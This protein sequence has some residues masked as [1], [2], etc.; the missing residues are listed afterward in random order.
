MVTAQ[1]DNLN[2]P[3]ED[4]VKGAPE[5][6]VTDAALV[7]HLRVEYGDR[8]V[9]FLRTAQDLLGSG[10]KSPCLGEAVVCCLRGAIDTILNSSDI[11][12]KSK[13]EWGKISREVVRAFEPLASTSDLNSAEA[14]YSFEELAARMGELDLF[15]QQEK[16]SVIR[17]LED[18]L[19][20]RTGF[21]LTPSAGERFQV[22]WDRLN[23]GIHRGATVE[24]AREMTSECFA[25]LRQLFMPPQ[26]RH[27]EIER[28]ARIVEPS[29]EDHSQ[30]VDLLATP[31]NQRAFFERVESMAWFPLLYESG[32]LYPSGADRMWPAAGAF[33]RF[34]SDNPDE[35]KQWFEKVYADRGTDP[36]V[37]WLVVQS[38]LS[39]G[40]VCLEVAFQAV[41]DHS[42]DRN[43]LRLGVRAVEKCAAP[44]SQWVEVFADEFLNMGNESPGR[45]FDTL[46]KRLAEGI[47]ATNATRRIELLCNKL[48]TADQSDL[49]MFDWNYG[50]SIAEMARDAVHSRRISALVAGLI[51]VLSKAS[52]FLSASEM[53]DALDRL[54]SKLSRV[55]SWVLAESLDDRCDLPVAEIQKGIESRFPTGDD[56][57]LIDRVAEKCEPSSYTDLWREALGTA[58]RVKEVGRALAARIVPEEWHRKHAWAALLPRE[59]VLDWSVACDILDSRYGQVTRHAFEHRESPV[60]K[61]G[62]DSPSVLKT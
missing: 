54:P 32:H 46:V 42:E 52:E 61:V 49:D 17:Q 62:E 38:G 40:E 15:H 37:A 23:Y 1:G 58:P 41:K 47:E 51:D 36:M 56:M 50:G 13:G 35:I 27:S 20:R 48:R 9:Q 5:T 14:R 19:S 18:V 31:N 24:D 2:G 4:S 30:L 39:M 6:E 55:R 3:K 43:V 25:V 44:E 60:V 26:V 8:V 16:G 29:P 28:L 34:A 57:R 45:D 10:M 22:L 53:L 21:D 12:T 59:V 11:L 33:E 7:D